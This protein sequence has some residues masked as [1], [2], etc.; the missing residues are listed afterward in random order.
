MIEK[1]VSKMNWKD[2]QDGRNNNLYF[3]PDKEEVLH[4]AF[5]DSP[6]EHIVRVRIEVA[7]E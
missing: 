6:E 4:Q 2:V 7:E 5:G 3:Y 1:I